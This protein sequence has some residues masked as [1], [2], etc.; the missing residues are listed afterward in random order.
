[1]CVWGGAITDFYGIRSAEE[2]FQFLQISVEVEDLIDSR[3]PMLNCKF[4]LVTSQQVKDHRDS[5]PSCACACINGTSKVHKV[6][7]I[8]GDTTAIYHRKSL[9]GCQNCLK[10]QYKD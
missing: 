5:F 1:M 9:C 4:F 10:V 7:K 8:S 6:V 3:K 2:L